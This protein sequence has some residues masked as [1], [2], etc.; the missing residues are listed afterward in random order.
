MMWMQIDDPGHHTVELP[1]SSWASGVNVNVTQQGF[2]D[3][4]GN[5]VGVARSC[6]KGE[7]HDRAVSNPKVSKLLFIFSDKM[8]FTFE[9]L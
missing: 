1:L 8:N 7:G 3:F 4:G 9:D 2:R 5:T 6:E